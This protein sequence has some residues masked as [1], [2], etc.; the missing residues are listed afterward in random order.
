MTEL[1]TLAD[2]C[3][4]VS[5]SIECLRDQMQALRA[6][7]LACLPPAASDSVRL[8]CDAMPTAMLDDVLELAEDALACLESAERAQ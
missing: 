3:A 7:D 2:G 8:L 4:D 1:H 6:A 5:I